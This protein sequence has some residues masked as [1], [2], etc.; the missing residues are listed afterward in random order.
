VDIKKVYSQV[1]TSIMKLTGWH[2]KAAADGKD[3][4]KDD[5][6]ARVS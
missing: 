6:D 4:Q 5:D 1:Y 2:L 3:Y